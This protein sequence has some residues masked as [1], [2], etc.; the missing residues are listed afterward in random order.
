MQHARPDYQPRIQDALPEDQGG[1]PATEPVFL[2]RAQDRLAALTVRLYALLADIA[3]ADPELVLNA[4]AQAAAR[5]A[6][7]PQKFPDLPQE[8]AINP[9]PH[10]FPPAP[11]TGRTGVSP[12]PGPLTPS[13]LRERFRV[14]LMPPKSITL[15]FY[16]A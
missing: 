3:G 15:Y 8:A 12:A 14:V 16:A 2:L 4:Q 1:I 11:F 7:D 10:H 6:W 13:P 9:E 5:E